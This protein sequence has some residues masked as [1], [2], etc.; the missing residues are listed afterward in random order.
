MIWRPCQ[1][2]IE[3][4][5]DLFES[6]L[7]CAHWPRSHSG[8]MSYGL[9]NEVL[10][11]CRRTESSTLMD[12]HFET[13]LYLHS[14]NDMYMWNHV[15]YTQNYYTNVGTSALY[16]QWS[17]PL[18][19]CPYQI[20]EH[21]YGLDRRVCRQESQNPSSW[22]L[23]EDITIL[24]DVCKFLCTFN[25]TKPE[26]LCSWTQIINRLIS[27]KRLSVPNFEWKLQEQSPNLVFF[28]ANSYN[29]REFTLLPF[30]ARHP[31]QWV[32]DNDP[33]P[34]SMSMANH[35]LSALWWTLPNEQGLE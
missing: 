28:F 5:L 24:M 2:D 13:H 19:S 20:V 6:F 11:G 34:W 10:S 23:T 21:Y 7:S 12:L 4:G 1:C 26:N 8:W 25:I 18:V 31:Q 33:L 22:G 9:P 27:R 15:N 29:L 3:V 17:Y 35:K 16:N 14:N 32:N 30:H